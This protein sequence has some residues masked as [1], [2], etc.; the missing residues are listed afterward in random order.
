MWAKDIK[1]AILVQS[2]SLPLRSLVNH[3]HEGKEGDTCDLP[4]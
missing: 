2:M 4:T 1:L 3:S